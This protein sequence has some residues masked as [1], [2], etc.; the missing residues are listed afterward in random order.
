MTTSDP[1]LPELLGRLS[2]DDLDFIKVFLHSETTN[3]EILSGAAWVVIIAAIASIAII[4]HKGWWKTI[5]K[6]YACS[7]D[8]K[9]IGIMYIV[10]SLVMLI[11]GV[12]E[13]VVMRAQQAD[14]LIGAGMHGGFLSADHYG[15]LFSTH[16]TIMIFFMAM[17]FLIGLINIVVPLQIGARDVAFPMLNSLSLGFTF[18]G[19]ALV[20][21]SLVIGAFSTG[22]WTAYPPYTGMDF[23][24]GPGPD[25]WLWS[26][27]LSGIG[28]TLTGMNFLVTIYK[29]RAP[30]MTFMRLPMF[31]WTAL[32]TSILLVFAMPPLTVAAAML[33]LDRYVDFHFFTSAL[34]GN[35]MNYANLF[36]LFGHPEVY[37]LILPAFGVFSE[38]VSTF[39]GKRL[40]GYGSLVIATMAIAVLSFTVW[41]HH[42]F[43][44]GQ[45]SNVNAAF[46]IATMLIGIPTGVKIYDWMATI[47][48]GR[49]RFTTPMIYTI[50]FML[51]F[52]L[53]G[54]TGIILANPSIDFQVHNTLFLV[55]H[56]HNMLIPGLLF[57]MLAGYT[58]WFPKVFGF[59]L[60]EFWGKMAAWSWAIGFILV[61][62]P[63]YV[64]GL[65]GM[66]RRTVSYTNPVYEPWMIV[67]GI[68]AVVVTWA[69]TSMVI[70]LYVSVRDR[71][72]SQDV[73]G[74]PWDARTLEWATPSP[75][76]A[77]NY[78][79][80]PHIFAREAFAVAKES[81]ANYQAPKAYSDIHL[82]GNTWI[83][84]IVAVFGTLLGFAMVWYIWWLAIAS[85]TVIIVSLIAR[86]L[87]GDRHAIT[88]PAAQIEAEHTTWL[89]EVRMV[90]PVNRDLENS[91]HNLGVPVLNTMEAS[92]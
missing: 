22:G 1:I 49:V 73:G 61:F 5:I 82:P 67:S 78:P 91:R 12:L 6:D 74:D 13:G 48:R 92:V 50:N 18:V 57:G 38:V 87:R 80:L 30:G 66:T 43:T 31:T 3:L 77:Y 39:S 75:V 19:A 33:L 84:L 62:F 4:T 10:I 32:C 76:P 26:V 58:F 85:F 51:L 52:V 65:L 41:L 71:E 7:V 47:F 14:G 64:V 68:G 20:M 83:G 15:Q 72:K 63:L 90:Q 88:I 11:R 16:G 69:L 46:G 23:Q 25:Y 44:M 42:F 17:P 36:W 54:L 37:I 79:V 56:F 40:Y 60:N 29:E 2:L 86:A 35:M 53:G 28:S 9:K 89:E 55:A 27:M 21:I 34:G 8:H 45:D 70:Q 24:P 59:R 81:D